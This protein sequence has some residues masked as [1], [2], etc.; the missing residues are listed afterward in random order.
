MSLGVRGDLDGGVVGTDYA[1]AQCLYE[2]DEQQTD[3]TH[4]WRPAQKGVA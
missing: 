3:E 4:P 1:L 2:T